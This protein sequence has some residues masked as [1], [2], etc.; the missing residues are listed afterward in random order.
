MNFTKL[1]KGTNKPKVLAI[2]WSDP[3]TAKKVASHKILNINDQHFYRKDVVERLAQ[4]IIE[5]QVAD[6]LLKV[7]NPDK[8][9]KK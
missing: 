9:I 2:T 6:G 1:F 8:T 7:V 5:K 4:E 3:R